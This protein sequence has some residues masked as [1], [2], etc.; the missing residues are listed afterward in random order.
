MV[1]GGVLVVCVWFGW[2]SEWWWGLALQ[3][4]GMSLRSE[5]PF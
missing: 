5:A 2:L 4:L 1:A 3:L